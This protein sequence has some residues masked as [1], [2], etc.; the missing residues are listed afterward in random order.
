M[1]ATRL[2]DTFDT[3]PIRRRCPTAI[4]SAGKRG[5]GDPHQHLQVP[6]ICLFLHAETPEFIAAD[7]AKRRQ[8]GEAGAIDEAQEQPADMTGDE[9]AV[10]TG[11]RARAPRARASRARRRPSRLRSATPDPG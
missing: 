8:V 2:P 11:C 7:G 6:A 1:P 9:A 5:G 3:P 10:A 4:S